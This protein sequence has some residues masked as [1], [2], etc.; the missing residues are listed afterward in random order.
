MSE[1]SIIIPSYNEIKTLPFILEKLDSLPFNDM[2][3]IVVD[4]GSIDGTFSYLNNI[5]NKFKFKLIPLKHEE[6]LGKG[7][8]ILTGIEY[9][10]G[11]YLIIQDA[12]L[13][14]DPVNIIEIYKKLHNSGYDVVFG[15]RFLSDKADTYNIL[16]LWG[17][18]FLTFL[19]NFLFL[20]KITDSYTCYKAFKT[21]IAKSLYLSSNGFEIEAEISCK[22]AYRKYS[23]YEVTIT[24]KSRSRKE[25]KKINF[26]D[27]IKG[28]LK[29]FELRFISF[30]KNI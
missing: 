23:Y 4:D 26:K 15:S 18:K 19:I 27:A 11:N 5:R 30:F 21:N 28:I 9:A 1:L 7:A 10:T 25:G 13:E 20:S 16:Y 6:N 29:I 22:V 14:Y 24:Y 12:D 8:A 2:E 3:V 17:N